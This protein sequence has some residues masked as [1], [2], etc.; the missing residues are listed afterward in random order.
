M[1]AKEA[2]VITLAIRPR[3]TFPIIGNEEQR[4]L[5]IE[6]LKTQNSAIIPIDLSVGGT[7][8]LI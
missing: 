4:K 1:E 6:L 3:Y 7:F 8:T 2:V 5:Y